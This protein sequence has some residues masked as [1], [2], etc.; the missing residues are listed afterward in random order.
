MFDFLAKYPELKREKA[1]ARKVPQ[2][3]PPAEG[4]RESDRGPRSRSGTANSFVYSPDGSGFTLELRFDRSFS[5]SRTGVL[6]AL[7]R[8]FDDVKNERIDV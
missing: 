3:E 5:L 7:K 4:S 1:V 8:A 6:T 2:A